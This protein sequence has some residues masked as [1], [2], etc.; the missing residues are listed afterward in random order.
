MKSYLY[1]GLLKHYGRTFSWERILYQS[2]RAMISVRLRKLGLGVRVQLQ[3]KIKSF[4]SSDH[5]DLK[6]GNVI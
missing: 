4:V 2:Q 6:L 1:Y 5:R 3:F